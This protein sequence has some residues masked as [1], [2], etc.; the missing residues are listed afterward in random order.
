MAWIRDAGCLVALGH[1]T[2]RRYLWKLE[3]FET[4]TS[5]T[6]RWVWIERGCYRYGFRLPAN[7]I[8]IDIDGDGA[9]DRW[10]AMQAK[11]L[12]KNTR[13]VR[14][15]SGG[16]HVYLYRC[17]DTPIRHGVDVLPEFGAVD[18]F[19]DKSTLITGPGSERR[20][21]AKKCAGIYRWVTPQ[22]DLAFVTPSLAEALKPP[23]VPEIEYAPAR[24]FEGEIA[25]YAQR[26]LDAECEAVA[27][28]G[29]HGRTNQ[30]FA[31]SCALGNHVGGGG[32][33]EGLVKRELYNAAVACGLVADK[34]Q[35]Y[36]QTQ[37]RNGIA[38]G[39]QTPRASN[40]LMTGGA[41][42]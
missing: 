34:G 14:T 20:A 39:R 7:I 10:R 1:P 6:L 4:K 19:T 42:G 18:V 9:P 17:P 28:S 3:N 38:K 12:I 25:I 41:R 21:S 23:P 8:V 32:L 30:L 37:I 22:K 13:I 40:R 15:P 33:P 11:Y 16:L 27:N 29:D 35:L 31:S 26:A 5:A 2:E 24:P 36:A